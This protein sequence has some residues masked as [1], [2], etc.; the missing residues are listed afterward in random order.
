MVAC[1][2][3][4][5]PS[6][7]TPS[8]NADGPTDSDAGQQ[9][10]KE[11]TKGLVNDVLFA[12][13]RHKTYRLAIVSTAILGGMGIV[14]WAIVQIKENQTFWDIFFTALIV[15][16]ASWKPVSTIFRIEAKFRQYMETDHQRAC[17]LEQ[18]VDPDRS[19]SGLNKDGTSPHG[20]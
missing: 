16:L 2:P 4:A 12:R 7:V 19:S 18:S 13:E 6:M 1:L 8:T 9:R 5:Y 10:E 11:P 20:T 3:L 15:I 17:E 14:A